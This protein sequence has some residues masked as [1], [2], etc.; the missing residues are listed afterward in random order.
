MLISRE[1]ST[2]GANSSTQPFLIAPRYYARVVQVFPPRPIIT[3]TIDPARQ[4]SSSSSTVSDEETA[5]IH[6]V[7]EDL[8]ISLADSITRD[9]PAKYYY[10][11]QILEE[12]KGVKPG[13]ANK[14]KEPSKTSKYS[15]SLMDVRCTGMR[16]VRCHFVK[17]CCTRLVVLTC[18]TSV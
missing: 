14:G 10:K 5:P 16:Y 7:A 12:D 9:D 8:K 13:A 2:S 1:T 4:A 6:K 15:G 3:S 11:I 17:A 18:F